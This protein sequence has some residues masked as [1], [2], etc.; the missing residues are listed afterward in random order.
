MAAGQGPGRAP[1]GG[2]N[3]FRNRAYLV[4]QTNFQRKRV[5]GE[6]VL[7]LGESVRKRVLRLRLGVERNLVCFAIMVT[8]ILLLNAI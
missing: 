1:G 8:C 4:P 2:L 6:C 7:V 5:D 3:D